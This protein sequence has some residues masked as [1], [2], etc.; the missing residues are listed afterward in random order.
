MKDTQ[1]RVLGSIHLSGKGE[2]LRTNLKQGP[3]ASLC[4]CSY[5]QHNQGFISI[6]RFQT[7]PIHHLEAPCGHLLLRFPSGFSLVMGYHLR[8]LGLSA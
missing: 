4:W 1:A 5:L 6:S 7:D 2:K 8:L 3:K